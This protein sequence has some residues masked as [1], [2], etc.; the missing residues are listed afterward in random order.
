MINPFP[1]FKPRESE[2]ATRVTPLVGGGAGPGRP[3]PPSPP[4]FGTIVGLCAGIA[5]PLGLWLLILI[6]ISWT[7]AIAV[8]GCTSLLVGGLGWRRRRKAKRRRAA[9]EAQRAAR[10]SG[11]PA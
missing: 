5:L 4:P 7:A 10:Q 11:P 9:Y 6:Q 1:F 3:A 8:L 2:R